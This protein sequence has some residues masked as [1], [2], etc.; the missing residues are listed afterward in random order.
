MSENPTRQAI[1]TSAVALA[2]AVA[3][4]A[5]FLPPLVSHTTASVMRVVLLGSVLS[6]AMVLHWF[7]L[8]RAAARL[9][10]SVL[11]WVALAVLLFPI[12]GAAALLVLGPSAGD[13]EP[14][15]G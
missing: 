11:G 15:H 9:G 2:A 5:A 14:A 6:L 13:A 10:R 1:T 3:C 8:G 4:I 7:Y 12:G